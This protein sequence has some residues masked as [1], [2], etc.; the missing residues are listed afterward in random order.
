MNENMQKSA[1]VCGCLF[2]RPIYF[3]SPSARWKLKLLQGVLPLMVEIG[4]F[5]RPGGLKELFDG[6]RCTAMAVIHH[7][8]Y[9]GCR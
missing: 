8:Y 3:Q 6:V 7:T 4:P 5:G 1:F 9:S 2:F